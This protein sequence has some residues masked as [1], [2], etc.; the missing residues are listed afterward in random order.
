M[1]ASCEARLN[2]REAMLAAL[3]FR[4]NGTGFKIYGPW[5]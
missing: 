5:V 2:R 4:V 1:K 3:G